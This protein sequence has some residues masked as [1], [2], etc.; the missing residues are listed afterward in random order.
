MSASRYTAFKARV[1]SWAERIGVQPERVQVQRMT[2]KWASCSAGGRLCFSTSLVREDSAFQ[3]V[4]IVHELLHLRVANHGR[5]FKSL[6][7]AYVPNWERTSA[8]R[9]S[10]VCH[11]GRG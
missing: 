9:V 4:V 5:L 11:Y 6:M 1:Q 8:S 3:E 2:R 10:R 7:N